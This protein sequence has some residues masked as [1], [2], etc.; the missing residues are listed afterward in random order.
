VIEARRFEEEFLVRDTGLEVVRFLKCDELEL[1][2]PLVLEVFSETKL[3]PML[4]IKA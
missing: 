2:R 3:K 1:L 4:M